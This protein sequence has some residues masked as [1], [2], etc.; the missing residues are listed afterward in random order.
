MA[1][2]RPTHT[3]R[4][5]NAESFGPLLRRWRQARG[6]SQ[7][8]LALSCGISQRHL[9]FLEQ[10]RSRPSRGMVLQLA[11][12]LSVPLRHQNAMMLAAGFAPAWDSCPLDAPDMA[13]VKAAID[14]M[15][16]SQAPY[17][18]V[19]VD[20]HYNLLQANAGTLRLLGFL[21]G[22]GVAD[23]PN[24][25]L[26]HL[27]LSPP[28]QSLV[29]NFTEVAGWLIRRLRAEAMLDDPLAGDG[30]DPF[31]ELLTDPNIAAL[32]P[33]LADGPADSPTLYIRFVKEGVRLSL[34]SLIA[35]LGT[36]LDAGLQNLRVELF[37][38]ADAA[39]RAWF[40]VASDNYDAI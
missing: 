22:P 4:V 25:N 37:Y 7:M 6:V 17:P 34:F 18:A 16:Q 36:P 12:N 35:T 19:L 31:A 3:R 32:A 9:S 20:R 40:Q 8:D 11:S 30:N 14:H 38:P 39:T 26:L 28:F 2:P 24:P 21:L 15:L 23:H 13:P 29:E 27:L 1:S 33:P 10:G 5:N